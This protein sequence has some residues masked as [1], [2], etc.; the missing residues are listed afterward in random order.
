MHIVCTNN[1]VHIAPKKH[2]L[3][4]NITKNAVNN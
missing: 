4:K 2:I 1:K 3:A